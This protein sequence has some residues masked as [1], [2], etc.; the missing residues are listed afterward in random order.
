MSLTP[1]GYGERQFT[2]SKYVINSNVPRKQF[3]EAELPVVN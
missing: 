2:R 3:L 1:N